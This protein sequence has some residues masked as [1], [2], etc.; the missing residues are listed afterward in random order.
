MLIQKPWIT[1]YSQKEQSMGK[2]YD[3][4][5]KEDNVSGEEHKREMSS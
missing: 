4:N 3:E 2:P 5:S 1:Y